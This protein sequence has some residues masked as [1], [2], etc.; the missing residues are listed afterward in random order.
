MSAVGMLFSV[1]VRIPEEE[2]VSKLA[3]LGQDIITALESA[4][5]MWWTRW[6]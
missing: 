2:S 5:G 3:T 1:R 6:D 4:G